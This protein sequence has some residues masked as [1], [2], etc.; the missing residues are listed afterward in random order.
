MLHRAQ[1]E[2]GGAQTERSSALGRRQWRDTTNGALESPLRWTAQITNSTAQGQI[3][4]RWKRGNSM[5]V[6]EHRSRPDNCTN[7]KLVGIRNMPTV[8]TMENGIQI[9]MQYPMI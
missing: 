4:S 6:C 2:A 1:Q 7:Y 8:A 3:R 5:A 9:T